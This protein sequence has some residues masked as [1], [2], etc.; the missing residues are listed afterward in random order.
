MQLQELI[1]NRTD[2]EDIFL[3][4]KKFGVVYIDNFFTDDDIKN[5]NLEFDKILDLPDS[6]VPTHFKNEVLHSKNL[7]PLKFNF[8]NYPVLNQIYNN[9]LFKEISK[10]Y[11][12]RDFVYAQKFFLVKSTGK[13]EKDYLQNKKLAFVPHT[14]EVNFLKFFIYLSDVSLSHGPLTV[15]PGTQ[16]KFRKIRHYW[17]KNNFDPLTRDKTN[18]QH[19]GEMIPLI[20]KKGTL[21]IFDTDCLH[22]AGDVRSDFRKI[23][24]V[25]VYSKK[26]NYTTYRQRVYL[27]LKK[28]IKSYKSNF[29]KNY[30]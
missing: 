22:K 25:D 3:K 24:R 6:S 4:L 5:L 19:E 28:I 29:T 9:N 8:N 20:G 27:K 7:N 26:E 18:Y 15:A 1:S 13:R 10:K 30:N 12:Q 2:K 11:F 14:D 17:I 21:I 16:N 23:I